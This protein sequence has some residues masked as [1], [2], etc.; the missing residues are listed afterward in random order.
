QMF[1][2]CTY[3][4]LPEIAKISKDIVTGTNPRDAKVRLAKEIVTLYHG[5]DEAEKAE[6]YFVET[7]S[8]G[9]TPQDV[10]EVKTS[11]GEKLLDV[12]V[13]SNLAESKGDARRKIEQGGV[14]IGDEKITDTDIVMEDRFDQQV[15]RVG[16]KDFVKIVF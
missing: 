9:H 7:F 13:A 16:K 12:I 5:A 11:V 3:I 4:S 1:V 8:K 6:T 2:D 14:A 10:R 15:M